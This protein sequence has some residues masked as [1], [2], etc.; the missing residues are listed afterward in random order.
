MCMRRIQ[1]AILLL[2][3]LT[4]CAGEPTQTFLNEPELIDAHA[5]IGEFRGY[6]LSLQNLL[7]NMK[8]NHVRYAL[9]SNIDGAAVKGFTAD[10]DEISINEAT[11]KAADQHSALIPLAWAKPGSR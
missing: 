8:E 10:S 7:L 1:L 3:S 2:T 4:V 9:I 11:A 5:H 6:N